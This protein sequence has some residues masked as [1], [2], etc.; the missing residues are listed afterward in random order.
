M[1][2]FFQY[3][4]VSALEGVT[5]TSVAALASAGCGAQLTFVSFGG[6]VD[7]LEVDALSCQRILSFP[8]VSLE[9]P[10]PLYMKFSL[11]MSVGYSL[12]CVVPQKQLRRAS[13]G[14]HLFDTSRI[15]KNLPRTFPFLQVL[16]IL[17]SVTL[18]T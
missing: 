10:L 6:E 4:R 1:E 12:S 11:T 13:L 16:G 8:P 18:Q 2:F 15:F 9:S 17:V 7:D 14:N 3:L 5:D